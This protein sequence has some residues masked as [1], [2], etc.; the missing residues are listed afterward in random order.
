M[1]ETIPADIALKLCEKSVKRT[2]VDGTH[3]M[4][5]GVGDIIDS[6]MKIQTSYVSVAEQTTEI[7]LM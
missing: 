2:E 5:C 4:E 3:S 6:Q 7:A 1:A